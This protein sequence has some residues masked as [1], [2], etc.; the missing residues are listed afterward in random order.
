MILFHSITSHD[1]TYLSFVKILSFSINLQLKMSLEDLVRRTQ[2]TFPYFV[3]NESVNL[4]IFILDPVDPEI[5]SHNLTT[6]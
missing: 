2:D 5:L 3:S 1:E 4:Q 6:M